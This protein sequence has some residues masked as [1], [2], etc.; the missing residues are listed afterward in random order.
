MLMLD[1]ST[2]DRARPAVSAASPIIRDGGDRLRVSRRVAEAGISEQIV[3]LVAPDSFAADQYRTLRHTVERLRQDAGVQ[4]LAVTSPSPGDGKSVTTLN[5]AGALAQSPDARVLVIDADLR[6]PSISAYLGLEGARTLGLANALKGECDLADTIRHLEHFNLA[7]LPAGAPQLS[8]YELLN[9]SRFD[10]L[11]KDARRDYTFVIIDTPPSVPL[12]DCRLI[13]R[14]LDGLLI[15]V[16]A[17][18]TPRRQLAETLTCLDPAKVVGVVFNGDD[19][20]LTGYYGYYGAALHG[21]AGWW[22]RL[23]ETLSGRS[24]P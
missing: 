10:D 12:P 23:R 14:S 21:R 22:T 17:H 8:P 16:A 3:S 11:I 1:R 4:V 20:P 2:E 19:R 18:K 7:V 9:S 15:V 13:E 24:R 6:R 5:L